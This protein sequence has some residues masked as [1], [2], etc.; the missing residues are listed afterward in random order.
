MAFTRI[1]LPS[2][3]YHSSY[4]REEA[5]S[6]SSNYGSCYHEAKEASDSKDMKYWN[7]EAAKVQEY[8]SEISKLYYRSRR[9]YYLCDKLEERTK[10]T[11]LHINFT[12]SPEEYVYPKDEKCNSLEE[13]LKALRRNNNITHLM[14]SGDYLPIL[15]N[16]Y[17]AKNSS[18]RK[19]YVDS[20]NRPD[21]EAILSYFSNATIRYI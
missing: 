8:G 6:A 20:Y 9:V 4:L 10:S 5:D 19:V 3:H 2:W 13:V 1:D 11:H 12:E 21:K 14:I 7:K 16:P 18:V 17:N 15:I